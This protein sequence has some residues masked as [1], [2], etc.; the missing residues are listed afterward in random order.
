[1][2]RAQS[3]SVPLSWDF[4]YFWTLVPSQAPRHLPYNLLSFSVVPYATRLWTFWYQSPNACCPRWLSICLPGLLHVPDHQSFFFFILCFNPLNCLR[5][6]LVG[7]SLALSTCSSM[8]CI[9]SLGPSLPQSPLSSH[10]H[11][12]S[13]LENLVNNR[14]FILNT[15]Q[16]FFQLPK[17]KSFAK[18]GRVHC[19]PE[20]SS[21]EL[22]ISLCL[23]YLG[24]VTNILWTSVSSKA[25]WNQRASICGST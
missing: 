13:V 14:S 3:Y 15:I 16:Q 22:S 19:Q 4:A 9:S 21:P 1:M 8:K 10:P 7:F 11:R 23:L 18:R 24:Q 25:M 5:S 20:G 17:L 6:Y 2:G 12:T